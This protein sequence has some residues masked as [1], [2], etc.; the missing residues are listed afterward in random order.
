MTG[1]GVCVTGEGVYVRHVRV[2]VCVCVTGEDVC[3]AK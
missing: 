3:C 2:C 1:E